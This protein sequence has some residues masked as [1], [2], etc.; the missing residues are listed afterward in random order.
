MPPADSWEEI[1]TLLASWRGGDRSAFDR[2]FT[3]LYGELRGLARGQAH[4]VGVAELLAPGAVVHVVE[5]ADEGEAC[6]HHLR[7]HR[8]SQREVGVGVELGGD[9]VHLLAPVPE[10]AAAA[11]DPSP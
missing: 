10:V 5:L 7:E 11:V 4:R 1:T 6:E 3:L 9:L 2:L 8:A